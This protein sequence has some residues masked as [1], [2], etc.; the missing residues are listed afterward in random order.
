MIASTSI[1]ASSA[2]ILDSL[3]RPEG[4][5]TSWPGDEIIKLDGFPN[6]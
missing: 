2:Q 4:K 5:A 1:G 3:L 6:T